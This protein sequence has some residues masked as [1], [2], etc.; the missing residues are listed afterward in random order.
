MLQLRF[1][2]ISPTHHCLSYTRSDGTGETSDL[3][4]KAF[5]MHDFL[6]FCVES[7]V[8][9]PD[10]FFVQLDKGSTYA[11]LAA[12]AMSPEAAMTSDQ[13]TERVVGALSGLVQGRGT[14]AGL[15]STAE[16]MYQ[17]Y[18]KPV[19]EWL[20]EKFVD[21][22]LER[23]RKIMGQWN[24]LAFGETLELVFGVEHS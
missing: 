4:T 21:R 14:V 20:N 1:T 8:P 18:Q 16:N 15:L 5:L 19:P 24:S 9:L 10:G 7:E 22:V 6:H 11:E 3:E 13:D 23:Y 12:G 17:A 2:R